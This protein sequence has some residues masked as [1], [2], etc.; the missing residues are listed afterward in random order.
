MSAQTTAK[1]NPAWVGCSVLD[2]IA[3]AD[4]DEMTAVSVANHPHATSEDFELAAF[5]LDRAAE[6]RAEIARR[7]R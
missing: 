6:M 2:L 7:V 5:M 1:P 3:A 4:E